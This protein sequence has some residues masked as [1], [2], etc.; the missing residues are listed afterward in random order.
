MSFFKRMDSSRNRSIDFIEFYEEQTLLPGVDGQF[1]VPMIME[2]LNRYGS[3]EQMIQSRVQEM[4]GSYTP[5]FIR[6]LENCV[7]CG[8]V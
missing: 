1:F 7:F 4:I 8:A 3:R 6:E 2:G 5:I